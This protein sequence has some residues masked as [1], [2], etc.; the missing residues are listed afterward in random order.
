MKCPAE[1]PADP[2]SEKHE[3]TGST[4][5]FPMAIPHAPEVA[6]GIWGMDGGV[7]GWSQIVRPH[8]RAMKPCMNGH[9]AHMISTRRIQPDDFRSPRSMVRPSWVPRLRWLTAV[10]LSNRE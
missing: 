5:V 9:P 3:L 2:S 1:R 6:S 10:I 4:L 8:P 7:H